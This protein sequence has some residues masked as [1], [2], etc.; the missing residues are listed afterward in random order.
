MKRDALGND[1][2]DKLPNGPVPVLT[3]ENVQDLLLADGKKGENTR[4]SLDRTMTLL[5]YL[6]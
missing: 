3:S 6:G 4:E 1:L 5:N 2:T